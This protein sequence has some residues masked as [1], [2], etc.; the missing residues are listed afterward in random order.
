MTN[1]FRVRY[2]KLDS[3]FA[4]KN[5]IVSASFI[6]LFYI[7]AKQYLGSLSERAEVRLGSFISP[8]RLLSSRKSNMSV[9]VSGISV[10]QVCGSPL[11]QGQAC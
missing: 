9:M 7:L 4:I 6:I 2:E 10:H 3:P 1:F 11:H 8:V 5:L